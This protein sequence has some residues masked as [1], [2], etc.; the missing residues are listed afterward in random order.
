MASELRIGGATVDPNAGSL[1]A[2]RLGV[3]SARGRASFEF[4]ARTGALRAGPD[5]YLGQTVELDIDSTLRFAGDIDDISEPFDS[6]FGWV[7][8]YRCT[9]LRS[10]ADRVPVTD[11]TARLDYIVFNLSGDDLDWRGSRAGRSLGY[12]LKYA[13]ETPDTAERLIELGI[14]GF[15]STGWG[16]QASATVSGG[17]LTFD[18]DDAGSGYTAAPA[19][20]LVG[21]DGTYT[22]AT[23]TVAAGE[24]TGV[25]ASGMADW[26]EAPEVWIGTLP[27]VTLDDLKRLTFIS[28]GAVVVAGDMIFAAVDSLLNNHEPNVKLHVQPDGTLRFHDLREF[29]GPRVIIDG[30][31]VGATARAITDS[32]GEVVSVEV[33]T[34]GMDYTTAEAYAVGGG[35]S[36]C[37]LSVNLSSDE[38]D[39]IDVDDG[40]TGYRY[41][42]TLTL[43]T[44]PIEP[45]QL[46]RDARG[47]YTRVVVRG[48]PEAEMVELR[49][50]K[51]D[52]EEDF[53]HDGLDND[54]AKTAWSLLDFEGGGRD[55]GT[56]T[57]CTSTTVTID[58]SDAARTYAVNEC[59]QTQR[60]GN[61]FLRKTVIANVESLVT[62]RV[63]SN[64]AMSAGGTCVLTLD[65]ALPATD[66]TSYTLTFLAGGASK[67][68][69][70]YR[71]TNATIAARMLQYASYP[72]PIRNADGSSVR[73][74]STPVMMIQYSDSGDPPY[75][76]SPMAVTVDPDTGTILADR[77]VVT[78]FGNRS[79]LITGGATTDGIPADVILYVPVNKGD[80]TAIVPPTGTGDTPLFAGSAFTDYGVERSLITS[81][82]T[83]RDPGQR[84]AMMDYAES[85]WG[86]VS[87]VP[88][89]GSILYRGL[90]SAALGFTFAVNLAGE[91]YT[92]GWE[93][94]ALPVTDFEVIWEESGVDLYTSRMSVSNRRVPYSAMNF[95]QPEPIGDPIGTD[96]AGLNSGGIS[97]TVNF[98]GQAPG[99]GFIDPSQWGM[100]GP[101]AQMV[102]G[103]SNALRSGAIGPMGAAVQAS[104]N[105][106]GTISSMSPF[107][108]GGNGGGGVTARQARTFNLGETPGAA[109]VQNQRER[110]A[111]AQQWMPAGPLSF[112]RPTSD[113][114]EMLFGGGG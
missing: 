29:A 69:R 3:Y 68:W 9:D 39:T 79:H 11:Y 53:D 109:V 93:T 38:V 86:S 45:F 36:G 51:G 56:V 8:L 52:L 50:S 71:V 55:E 82:S 102:M 92:T 4:A 65:R 21:G 16:A 94:A 63:V 95:M 70:Q 2:Y 60:K 44:D 18:V 87:D 112:I 91:S 64:T 5:L 17:S 32:S 48:Q 46:Q 73:M 81:V 78:V 12:I 41:A 110:A 57:A 105:L 14:G 99:S 83:W 10:R 96:L 74:T 107:T 1:C 15:S 89:E 106:R 62:R 76:E 24:V 35:G 98:V 30:D 40:G 88:I 103:M 58:S 22:S 42:R 104:N 113:D 85:I 28:P 77:P 25:S 67:V 20:V 34:P 75:F 6:Q 80:L 66:Y 59:D 72:M 37:V 84:D 108:F 27:V 7:Q 111:R 54:D 43:G 33:L 13:I 19:V 26:T 49:L 31:G 100:A 23:A 114:E 47:C 90:Y 101:G 97:T 61:V